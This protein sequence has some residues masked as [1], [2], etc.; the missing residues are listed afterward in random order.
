MVAEREQLIE[1]ILAYDPNANAVMLGEAFDYA[2]EVH[3]K[4][5]RKSGEPY[6]MHPLAVANI[7]TELKLDDATVATGLLHD[8]VED[9]EATLDKIND[10]FGSEIRDLV[11]GVTKIEKLDLSTTKAKQAEN[12]RKLL[13]AFTTDIRVLLVKLADR[14]HNMRTMEHMKASAQKRISEETLE[15]YA[16]LAARLGIHWV[17]EELEEHAF[18]WLH[19]KAYQAINKD[20]EER[21]EDDDNLV[22]DICEVI[23]QILQE[24]GIEGEVYGREKKPFSIWKKMENKQISFDQLSDIYAFRI[25]VPTV[26]DCYKVLGLVHTKWPIVPGF[27]KDYIS[28]SKRNDYQ[29]LHTKVE[30]PR[31]QRVE[32][33]I[34]TFD[35]HQT[36]EYGIAAH[37]LYKEKPV[38]E[39]EK[40][41]K[42]SDESQISQWLRELVDM[43]RDG[44]NSETLYEHT[45]M[46]LYKDQVFCF[47][48][49][50]RIIVL[51]YGATPLDFAYAV[52]TDVGNSFLGCKINGE[53]KPRITALRNGD[54]VEIIR[55]KEE[56]VDTTWE[57]WVVTGKA[58]SAIRKFIRDNK[59]REHISWGRQ[60]LKRA[61]DRES[62]RFQD[63][64]IIKNIKKFPQ[65][66]IDDLFLDIGLGA[67]SSESVLDIIFKD[68]QRPETKERMEVVRKEKG[69]RAF[70]QTVGIKY[71]KPLVSAP[72]NK[73]GRKGKSLDQISIGGQT[74]KLPVS[75]A[76]KG[77]AVPG[78]RI[79]GVL[80]PEQGITI[81]PIQ[82][83]P[84]DLLELSPD[85]LIDVTW[86]VDKKSKERFPAQIEVVAIN[87]PGSLVQIA[88]VISE[89]KGNIH[90]LNMINT[91]PDYTTMRFE[92][93]VL[94]IKHLMTIIKGVSENTMVNSV[95]RTFN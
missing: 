33:Q 32:L 81:Y 24:N 46:E 8:T 34:R 85:R 80:T 10:L 78:D 72:K 50:G 2:Q 29:S 91:A 76:P 6:F 13:V 5:I 77:G 44:Q 4:D 31:H 35:M 39:G 54:K 3:K 65:D 9:T 86:D 11:D 87:E 67:V 43:L 69:W 48:P 25:L 27:F 73:K 64:I 68:E 63:D 38:K 19:P 66:S 45:K 40:L 70:A 59:R 93:E 18:R 58:R 94:D 47:T 79:V 82:S 17:R 61:F 74:S 36:A 84:L 1:N 52:H 15:V 37:A 88:Q 22:L 16:P 95:Q 30:G 83:I 42:R 12:F 53:H 89:E 51:P 90:T 20:L 62:K 21:R 56:T 14:L 23:R 57:N 26:L 28:L 92:L 41:T 71:R 75:Y 60:M 7:L 49:K 55:A